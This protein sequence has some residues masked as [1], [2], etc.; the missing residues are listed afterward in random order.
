MPTRSETSAARRLANGLAQLRAQ[1]TD[2]GRLWKA[3]AWLVAEARAVRRLPDMTVGVLG[4]VAYLRGRLPLPQELLDAGTDLEQ[5]EATESPAHGA[6]RRRARGQSSASRSR[7][8]GT[9][10]RTEKRVG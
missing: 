7:L 9:T 10:D 2:G 1:T 5:A 6:P 4:L 3:C 8:L